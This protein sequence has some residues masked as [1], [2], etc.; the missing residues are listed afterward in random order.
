MPDILSSSDP[1]ILAEFSES[2]ATDLVDS[3]ARLKRLLPEPP[4]FTHQSKNDR[5]LAPR[6]PL[7]RFPSSIMAWNSDNPLFGIGL[8]L[9]PRTLDYNLLYALNDASLTLLRPPRD[10]QNVENPV[11][12]DAIVRRL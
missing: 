6:R 3:M 10:R 2:I 5:V 9:V 7:D 11:V 1:R 4:K 12:L 8:W